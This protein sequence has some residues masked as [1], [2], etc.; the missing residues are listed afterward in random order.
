[1]SLANTYRNLSVRH[2]LRLI[3]MATVTAALLCA[4]AAVLVYDRIAEREGMRNDL[5]V[6]AQ[7]LGGNSTAALTLK[8]RKWGRKFC[9][10]SA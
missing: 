8:T 2:K 10:R 7:M 6:M 1:M 5:E 3:V 4:C 9:P